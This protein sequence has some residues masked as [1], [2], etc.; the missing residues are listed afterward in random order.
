[1]YTTRSSLYGGLCGRG[2]S[3]TQTTLDRD[4]PWTETPWTEALLDRDP[5]ERTWDQRQRPPRRNMGRRN[6]GPGSQT[7]NSIIQKPLP[8][9]NRM[10][11]TCL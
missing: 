5:L 6:M 3:L 8:P 11:D 2:V 1:M 9:V 7:G 10:T 4:P